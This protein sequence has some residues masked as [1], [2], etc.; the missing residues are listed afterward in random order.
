M[1][2]GARVG[3][4]RGM[5]IIAAIAAATVMSSCGARR[6]ICDY[7]PSVGTIVGSAVERDG[8]AVTFVV[9]SSTP[10]SHVPGVDIVPP[11]SVGSRV[12][13]HYEKGEAQF[14]RTGTRYRVELWGASGG[15]VS[16]VR[17]AN[18]ACSGGTVRADGAAIETSLWSRSGVRRLAAVSGLI[19][20]GLLVISALGFSRRR[21]RQRAND[22]RIKEQVH[23]LPSGPPGA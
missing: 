17:T 20:V 21:H 22:V 10:G 8:S 11:P 1:N 18:R 5:A 15:L 14:L 3:V 23:D 13:V 9:E 4:L 7:A 6:T 2:R 19:L 12:I 16:G